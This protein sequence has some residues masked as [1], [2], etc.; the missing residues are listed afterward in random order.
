MRS[1]I[2]AEVEALVAARQRELTQQYDLRR[3]SDEA[4][5]LSREAANKA[6]VDFLQRR[7]EA[8]DCELFAKDSQV[9]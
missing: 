6:S 2:A 3:E 5:S 1:S 8:K 9:Q 7:L 4:V